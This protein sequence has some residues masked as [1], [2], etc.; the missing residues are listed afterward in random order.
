MNVAKRIRGNVWY[1][2]SN[3]SILEDLGWEHPKQWFLKEAVKFSYRNIHTWKL[4]SF[5]ETLR[6]PTWRDTCDIVMR[7][8]PKSDRTK[9]HLY[10]VS[11]KLYNSLPDHLKLS[12]PNQ[13]KEKLKTY[14]LS[15]ISIRKEVV[16]ADSK[17]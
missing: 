1:R 7:Q 3:K 6:F 5:V 4:A 12:K 11:T 16:K 15:E 17:D 9:R 8:R 14:K 10:T 2:E 13:F